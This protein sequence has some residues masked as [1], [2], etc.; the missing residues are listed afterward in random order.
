MLTGSEKF[1][2]FAR[3][4]PPALW[5]VYS[6][7]TRVEKDADVI[8]NLVHAQELKKIHNCML[9]VAAKF[10]SFIFIIFGKSLVD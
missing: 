9:S 8:H 7:F 4:F 2:Q 3:G 5:M 10:F 6:N 1:Y